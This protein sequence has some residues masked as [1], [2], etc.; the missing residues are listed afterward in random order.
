MLFTL[1]KNNNINY[2]AKK[3]K[4]KI[5]NTPKKIKHIHKTTSLET[6]IKSR[7]NEKCNICYSVKA[8]HFNRLY[9]G[10]CRISIF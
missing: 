4:K 2:M 5:F 10:K 8:C 1:I 3:H 9:C 6:F 7:N